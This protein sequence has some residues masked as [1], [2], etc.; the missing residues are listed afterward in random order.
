MESPAVLDRDVPPAPV[1]ETPPAVSGPATDATAAAVEEAFAL[2]SVTSPPFGGAELLEVSPDELSIGANT[3]RDVVL[4]KD[5]VRSIGRHGVR[6]PIRAYRDSNGTLVVHDGQRRTLAALKTKREIVR[7]IVEP[8]PDTDET[9]LERTRIVDQVVVNRHRLDITGADQVGATQQLLELGLDARAI[10]RECS[11]PLKEVETTVRV[12]KSD[13]ARKALDEGTLDLTQAAVVAEF[14]DDDEAVASLTECAAQRPEQFDHQAQRLRD[15]REEKRLRQEITDKLTAEGITVVDRPDN[16]S[17]GKARRLTD[18][19][20]TPTSKPGIK[21]TPKRHESCAGHAAYL[22]YHGW[23]PADERVIVT[24]ICTDFAGHG[25]AERNAGEGKTTF[26]SSTTGRV[27]GPMS[28]AEKAARRT[29]IKNGKEW[30]SAVK[31]RTKFLKSFGARKTAPKDAASW[32]AQMWAEGGTDLRKAMEADHELAVTLLNIKPKA[33]RTRYNRKV[34]HPIAEAAAKATPGRATMINLMMLLASIE[35]GTDRRRTWDT[36]TAAQV[37]YFTQLRSW[38]YALS[39]VEEMVVA[40]RDTAVAT[41]ITTDTTE[42]AFPGS[43]DGSGTTGEESEEADDP[44]E[45]TTTGD[46]EPA[47]QGDSITDA[48]ES[49]SDVVTDPGHDVDLAA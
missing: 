43:E 18:L 21:I 20:A 13:L 14:S 4:D 39:P 19:R 28:E 46:D 11:I 2:T 25:H 10:A 16:L 32:I 30:D 27:A 48:S 23:K 38:G 36:P 15:R 29:V 1:V 3:R 44:S 34:T 24:H 6:E 8:L 42:T 41:P 31:V 22:D 17:F 26:S 33:G 7:V 12:A 49:V 35:A 47:G 37:S 5:F 45:P 40:P 9:E